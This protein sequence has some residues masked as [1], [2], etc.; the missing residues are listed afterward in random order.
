MTLDRPSRT[1][2]MSLLTLPF[3]R[4]ADAAPVLQ[5]MAT[6][7]VMRGAVGPV[8]K[9]IA[10]PPSPHLPPPTPPGTQPIVAQAGWASGARSAPP[11][12]LPTRA[13]K[14][15]AVAPAATAPT[16]PFA[17]LRVA[18]AV[19]PSRTQ[20]SRIPAIIRRSPCRLADGAPPATL[21]RD[22]HDPQR[23]RI[24][25]RFAD[26][27]AALDRLVARHEGAAA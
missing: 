10:M 19:Q 13:S 17:G 3:R 7:P 25:G 27:C 21:H 9:P 5:P 2:W 12:A 1:P 14:P 6:Q 16:A 15:P 18:R 24:S 20:A 23:V 11:Q 22:P 4:T 8:N 26:V